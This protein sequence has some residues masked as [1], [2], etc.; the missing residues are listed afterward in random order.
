MAYG[1]LD[2]FWPDGLFRTFPLT[3]QTSSIGRSSGN[4][5]MLDTNTIS[6]YHI[7]IAQEKGQ[8]FLTDLDSVNGTFIDGVRLTGSE[9]RALGGGEEIQIG[10]L[11][12][13][14]HRIDDQ[15]TQPMAAVEEETQRVEVSL[16]EFNIHVQGPEQ[17]VAP[18]AHI[19]AQLIISNTSD[20]IMRYAVEVDGL[21]ADWVRLDRPTP[22]ITAQNTAEVLINIKPTRRYDSKPGIYPVSVRVY[23]QEKPEMKLQAEITLQVLP[24]GG[25]GMALQNQRLK[26]KERFRLHLHNQGS[27][28]LPLTVSAAGVDVS[29]MALGILAGA[30]PIGGKASVNAVN[31]REHVR[32]MTQGTRKTNETLDFS[33]TSAKVTLAPGARQMVQLEARPKRTSMFGAPREHVFDVSVRSGDP[34]GFLAVQRAYYTETPPLPQWTLYVIAAGILAMLL[35][36]V[37]GLALVLRQPPPQPVITSLTVQG[38]SAQI[39][40]GETLSITWLA[41]DVADL[42][43]SLNGTPVASVTDPELNSI[44]LS[45]ENLAGQ[46][47]VSLLGTNGDQ[48]ASASQTINVYQPMQAEFFA[49]EPAQMVRYVVQSLSLRWNVPGAVSTRLSGVESFSNT[50]LQPTFGAQGT[51]SEIVGVPQNPFSITLI[52]ED[53]IG[54]TLEQSIT[55]DVVN[56]ECIPAGES[57]ILRAGPDAAHQVVGTLNPG[58]RVVVD[59]QDAGRRWLRVQLSGGVTGWGQRAE[60]ACAPN[61]NVDNLQIA[62]NVLPAPT[63]VIPTATLTSTLTATATPTPTRTSTATRPASAGIGGG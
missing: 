1:R 5:I 21:P 10:T 26:G 22:R 45:T 46:V 16:P 14:Y 20:D 30:R 18:G 41:T 2:V 58:A 4:T 48:Q 11:R 12:I 51:I 15:P 29:P 55:I 28:N 44:N 27:A 8:V 63:A 35:L 53:E 50:P 25:F 47:I 17:G 36:I 61:F 23:P 52:A 49:A 24:F 60:F 31:A 19:S 6:R 42:S 57:V 13:I 9:K 62:V 39:P 38:G 7:S 54:N 40:R 56:P 33:I 43:I 37:G 59:A 32:L 34:S 3:E